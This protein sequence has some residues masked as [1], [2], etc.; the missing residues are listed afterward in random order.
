MREAERG[1]AVVLSRE[2]GMP[3]APGFEALVYK[4]AALK[5]CI[6]E[7]L[8]PARGLGHQAVA[9]G[10]YKLDVAMLH[11]QALAKLVTPRYSAEPKNAMIKRTKTLC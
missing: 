6:R 7:S 3:I 8:Q 1:D 5:E 4:A 11:T 9:S 10:F 2:F